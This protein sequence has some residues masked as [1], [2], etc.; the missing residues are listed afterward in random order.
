MKKCLIDTGPM[1]ALFNKSDKYHEKVI[2]FMKDYNGFLYTTWPVLTEVLYM[3]NFNIQTQL[4]FMRW[5]DTGAV[6]VKN[7]ENTDISEIIKLI[8]KYSDIPMDLADASLVMISENENIKEII[9]IDSDFQ[10]Y[11]S[12]KKKYLTNIFNYN[13]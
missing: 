10:I 12:I 9:S 7:L 4:D 6:S 3:L 8:D 5:I 11:R 1:I 13:S 2:A